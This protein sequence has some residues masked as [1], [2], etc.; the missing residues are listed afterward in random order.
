MNAYQKTA[1][2]TLV[3]VIILITVG[4][5]VRVAGAGL[6]CPDWPLCWGCWL[7]PSSVDDLDMAYIAEKG[8]DLAEFNPTK[9]WIEYIN[10][11]V[12]VAIGF[13]VFAT[14][15]RSIRYRATQAVIFRCSLLS[16]LLVGFQGWLGGQVV[17]SGLVPGII[18]LHMV[19]ALV[20][21]GLLI[22]TTHEATK[23]DVD[24]TLS[25]GVRGPFT[26][27]AMALLVL[28]FAQLILGTQVREAVDPFIKDP[29]GLARSEWLANAGM[30]DHI[31]R[32]SS[33]L[34]LVAGV[35]LFRFMR[36]NSIAGLLRRLGYWILMGIMGQMILG[37][38]LAYGGLPKSAQVLHL[39]IA[40]FLICTQFYV[41]L[42]AR[43]R[44]QHAT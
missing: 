38:I 13:L 1:I 11:M 37:I 23:T 33:W 39:V 4:S 18:T 10:R 6:G 32:A 43:D 25:E 42:L 26:R 34:V 12:G 22:F 16:V 8:F 41:I 30:V 44:T 17:Q 24:I 31:H 35:F 9:M 20:L 15:L 5:L 19:L 7:P 36:L 29:G 40:T 3:A 14:F 21:V 28:T 2:T 27:I